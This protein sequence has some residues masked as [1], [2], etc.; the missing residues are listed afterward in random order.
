MTD[1]EPSI[2]SARHWPP[3]TRTW[4][5][6]KHL[7][8]RNNGDAQIYD[9]AH[10]HLQTTARGPDDLPRFGHWLPYYWGLQQLVSIVEHS[11]SPT[12]TLNPRG[13]RAVIDPRKLDSDHCDWLFDCKLKD[14]RGPSGVQPSHIVPLGNAEFWYLKNLVLPSLTDASVSAR[15][16]KNKNPALALTYPDR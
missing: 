11:P 5:S 7:N 10:R 6:P 2:F 8:P 1:L 14:P 9:H 3:Y 16:I 4:S 13:S 15:N 12:T